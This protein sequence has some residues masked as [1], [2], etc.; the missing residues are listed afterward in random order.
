[1][2]VWFVGWIIG[3]SVV[4]FKKVVC[5]CV[6]VWMVGQWLYERVAVCALCGGRLAI[7]PPTCTYTLTYLGD[8]RGEAQLVN[9]LAEANG[10]EPVTPLSGQ[11]RVGGVER[12]VHEVGEEPVLVVVGFVIVCG[13]VLDSV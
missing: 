8:E 12:L 2:C 7:D 13:C 5:V 1:V 11:R 9:V 3:Q 10:L 4:V 6:Y